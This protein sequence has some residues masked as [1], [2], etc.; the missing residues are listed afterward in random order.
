M[1]EETADKLIEYIAEHRKGKNVSL[2]WFGGEPLVGMERIDQISQGLKDR[3]IPYSASMTSNGY[4]F[5]EEIVEKSVDLWHL[6]RIQITLDGTEEVYNQV[7][8]YAS[9]RGSPFQRVLRNIDLLSSKDILVQ[10]R[11]NV[12]L[13]NKENIR[14]LIEQLGERYSG[15]THV[16]VYLNMLFSDVGFDPVHHSKDEMVELMLVIDEYTAR[17]KELKLGHERFG[18]PSLKVQQCM[19]DNPH[20]VEIQ[21]D[22]GFC[23]CEHENVLDSYGNIEK[24]A[25]NPQKVLS[26]KESI[27]RSE[28]CPQC[29]LYPSCFQLR[30]CMNARTPCD[31][32]LR[33]RALAMYEKLF[34][35][36]Y[37][38][39]SQEEKKQ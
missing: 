32:R 9:V 18:I 14:T 23:R 27:R 20:S 25:L 13:Y 28:Y 2:N 38:Q 17:L 29:S 22:G 11:L 35:T 21:P 36:V 5:D 26:W 10:I 1:T 16:I 19:A 7:K 4:L 15:N 24:G 31:E 8:A 33:K 37:Q 3:N 12:D 6:K 34:Y 30:K 39:R